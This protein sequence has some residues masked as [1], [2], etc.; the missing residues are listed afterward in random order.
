MN[1]KGKVGFDEVEFEL[2]GSA[3]SWLKSPSFDQLHPGSECAEN[4]LIDAKNVLGMLNPEKKHIEAVSQKLAEHLAADD[5]F[6]L[7]WIIF[8]MQHGV[9]L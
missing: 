4:A 5:P 6:W 1:S 2:R 8:A 3:D 9:E 7:R